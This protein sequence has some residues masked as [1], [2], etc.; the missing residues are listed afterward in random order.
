MQLEQ[1]AIYNLLKADYLQNK[2]E[3]IPHWKIEDYRKKELSSLF[4]TL[5][6][7]K[8]SL[9]HQSFLAYAEEVHSPE[10]LTEC[11]VLENTDTET[12]DHIF[13]ILFELW[14][15]LVPEKR[16]LSIFCDELDEQICLYDQETH[17]QE[18][19]LQLSLSTILSILEENVDAGEDPLLLF[20]MLQTHSI[21]D[22]EAF[23]YDFIAE[24]LDQEQYA[25][26][27]ELIDGF[28]PFVI[29]KDWFNLLQA[30]LFLSTNPSKT[31]SIIKELIQ[32]E[33]IDLELYLETL[34]F[35]SHCADEQLFLTL[36]KKTI[37]FLES[38]DQLQDLLLSTM[39]Y[40][41]CLDKE[42]EENAIQQ[43]LKKR[44][45]ILSDNPV[46]DNI[47]AQVM[48]LIGKN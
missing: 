4:N 42:K 47:L 29:D 36:A 45:H 17:K 46:D 19:L 10:E 48:I 9:N 22:L 8:I 13:L 40:Y 26:A 12:E 38:E 39:Q 18:E 35:L 5:A 3:S 33:P 32:K 15:R 7:L 28:Y 20:K 30:R 24:K 11:L 2:N 21:H 43:L 34:Q 14:R 44:E 25:Y 6:S 16:P 37:P 1:K 31:N 27:S 23:L 41:C